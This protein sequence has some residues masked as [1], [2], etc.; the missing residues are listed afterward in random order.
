M[1]YLDVLLHPTLVMATISYTVMAI[2]YE[3]AY[4]HFL[5]KIQ[6]V[7]G[8]HWIAKHIGAP[9]FH[10]LLL[11][12]FIYMS[13]PVLYGLDSH[14]STGEAIL[15]SL[16]QLLN[17]RSGQTMKLVNTLFIISVILPLIPVINRFTAFILPLQAIAGS[18][19]LYGWLADFTGIRYSI[20]PGFEIMALII[21]FSFI[22]E[23][24]ARAIASL[25]GAGLHHQYRHSG[26]EKIIH[27]SMLLILQ[28]P[29]LLIYTLNITH[30]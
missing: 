22:A 26:T 18:A 29:I 27:K 24:A 15:P 7:S 13:Y 2:S 19:V 14:N 20:F 12:A 5:H 6:A 4:Q 9:F 25:S 21:F 3:I 23:L 11:I 16:S 28:V 1:D 30:K 17:A 8:S 10:V